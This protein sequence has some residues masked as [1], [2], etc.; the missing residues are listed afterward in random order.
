MLRKLD[1]EGLRAL[2][3][4]SVVTGGMI[5]KIQAAL[6]AMAGGVNRVRMGDYASLGGGTATE[7]SI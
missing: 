7:V 1:V 5:P 2:L 4:D 3:G 6:G